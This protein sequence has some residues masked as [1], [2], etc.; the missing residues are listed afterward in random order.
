MNEISNLESKLASQEIEYIELRMQEM[1]GKKVNT[2]GSANGLFTTYAALK[3][4][5]DCEA[6]GEAV[7]S[8]LMSSVLASGISEYNLP[9]VESILKGSGK[10][11]FCFGS[12]IV[13]RYMHV[14]CGRCYKCNGSGLDKSNK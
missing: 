3:F 9:I 14:D 8:E 2:V 12:G 13:S 10:C 4:F 6:K 11:I 1:K 7:A 5:R